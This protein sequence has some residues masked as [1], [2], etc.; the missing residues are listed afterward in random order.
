MTIIGKIARRPQQLG[1]CCIAA[2][3]GFA[4]A[5]VSHQLFA[6]CNRRNGPVVAGAFHMVD[7]QGRLAARVFLDTT[8][9]AMS[10]TVISKEGEVLF[11]EQT[12]Y[13]TRP[14]LE[15]LGPDEEVLF[16]IEAPVRND[17]R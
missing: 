16:S 7:G 1:Y 11:L 17:W 3:F 8:K 12:G 4:G 14:K 6:S 5:L 10:T 2:L 13:S 9:P 15:I